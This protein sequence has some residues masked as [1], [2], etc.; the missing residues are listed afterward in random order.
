MA[1]LDLVA[2][3]VD[4]ICPPDPLIVHALRELGFETS[5]K[6]WFDALA[7]EHRDLVCNMNLEIVAAVVAALGADFT[8]ALVDARVNHSDVI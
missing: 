8:A 6:S 3:D 4:A 7:A 5:I 1:S 2:R